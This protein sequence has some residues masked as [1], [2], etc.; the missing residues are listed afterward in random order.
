MKRT[1]IALLGGAALACCAAQPAG[2]R[3]AAE[4]AVATA[5]PPALTAAQQ[6]Y[7]ALAEHG[8]ALAAV[9]LAQLAPGLVRLAARRPRPLPAGDDLGHR[10]AVPGAR[11]DRDR[12]SP[13]LRTARAV[14][15]FAAGR[16][17]LPEPRAAPASP[18]TRPIRATARRARRRGSTTTAGGGSR[19]WTPTA[20]PAARRCSPTPNARCA[21]SPRAGWDPAA[22]RDLVEHAP[23]LQGGPGARLRHAARRADLQADPL[24]LRARP[25]AAV[26]APGR[27]R[28]ASAPPT[29]STRAARSNPTPIDYIEG[30]LI[31]AQATLCRLTGNQAECDLAERLKARALSRFG[32]LL[33]FSPQYDAIYLQWMLALYALDGDATLYRMAAD[34]ARNAQTRALDAQRPVPA[35]L[36]RRDAARRA[37]RCRGCSRRTRRRRACSPGWP[38]TRRRPDGA[39]RRARG[40]RSDPEPPADDAVEHAV[41]Q[42][43]PARSASRARPGR[44][45]RGRASA[46]R[47]ARFSIVSATASGGMP[48]LA[49]VL[50]RPCPSSRRTPPYC[51]WSSGGICSALGLAAALVPDRRRDRARLDQRDLDAGAVQLDAQRVADRLDRVLGG[52]VGAGEAPSPPARRSRR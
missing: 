16:R 31:Y 52:R 21:T 24:E 37:T 43:P 50:Q 11:R 14:L 27:T 22:R 17:A 32:Y 39:R 4:P 36:E 25:G 45:A 34:N 19:S 44:R 40:G 46:A 49:G 9:A 41:G 47:S 8:V 29:A 42:Q 20:R 48:R 5:P 12:L 26:P 38:C 10:A 15:R 35:R 30:P 6:R 51:C 7:L 2:A 33:D 3:P 23:P 28:R 1:L 13:R 18:A